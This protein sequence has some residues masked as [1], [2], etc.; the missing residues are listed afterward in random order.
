MRAA[1][2]GLEQWLLRLTHLRVLMA[3]VLL[4]FGLSQHRPDSWNRLV[5]QIETRLFSFV[6]EWM[7][8]PAS[9]AALTVIQVPDI[10]FDAWQSDPTGD[11]ELAVLLGSLA[12]ARLDTGD[13]M[14]PVGVWIADRPLSVIQTES[15]RRMQDWLSS[16]SLARSPVRDEAAELAARRDQ[17]LS[18]LGSHVIGLK[19]GVSPVA[20]EPKSVSLPLPVWASAF[21]AWRSAI[22]VRDYP[23]QATA[24][25]LEYLSVADAALQQSL[26]YRHHSANSVAGLRES[27]ALRAWRLG[28]L[29]H[30]HLA[31]SRDNPAHR[32]LSPVTW[33]QG[34]PLAVGGRVLNLGLDG[35]IL[36][37][38][39]E[40]TALQAPATQMTLAAALKQIAAASTPPDWLHGWVLW[41]REGDPSLKATAQLIAAIEDTAYLT[42]PAWAPWVSGVAWFLCAIILLWGLPRLSIGWMLVALVAWTLIWV[43]CQTLLAVWFHYWLGLAEIT[44][45]L[46][47]G[48]LWWGLVRVRLNAYRNLEQGLAYWAYEAAKALYH[49]ERYPESLAALR[50]VPLT[51]NTLK[52]HYRLAG[53]LLDNHYTAE[54]L[55]LWRRIY[56]KAK[57]FR[58]VEAQLQAAEQAA[59]IQQPLQKAPDNDIVCVPQALEQLGRYQIQGVLG[60]GDAGLVYLGFDPVIERHVA[61]KVLNLGALAP[62]VQERVA[63]QFNDQL[64]AITRLTHPNI[65]ALVDH[66][67]QLPWFFMAFERVDAKPLGY[68][69]AT[70]AER[71][72]IAEIYGIGL[73]V[74]QA[75][76]A[77]HAQGIVHGAIKP[78]NILYDRAS[79]L[80]KVTDFGLAH[81]LDVM[82]TEAGEAIGNPRYMAPEQLEGRGLVPQ[83]D[84]FSLGAVLYELLA[85]QPAF[86]AGVS[87]QSSSRIEAAVLYHEP[88]PIRQLNP[89]VPPGA[90]RIVQRALKKKTVER[91]AR[92]SDLVFTLQEA[93]Q[94]DYPEAAARWI[95]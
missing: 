38:Y 1:I 15:H 50:Q 86:G 11:P 18:S 40:L 82:Q 81:W 53:A 22:R 89:E 91:Y 55:S 93:L 73:R 51:V 94:R 41:G 37:L 12:K 62:V 58:D 9:H 26:I 32:F 76:V 61:L 59:L 90:A 17:A 6:V 10:A 75:L 19:G 29:S 56:K 24:S 72:S 48:C 54:A 77:A 36:P 84:C 21:L 3:L 60:H 57:D 45:I 47:G 67:E 2:I 14:P 65:V 35:Q 34:E 39:T 7:P 25:A 95:T 52:I 23:L 5:E 74:A 68:Y 43:L 79:G 83:T 31:P 85:G 78:S 70:A 33:Q 44:A 66:G 49:L 30:D 92:V 88:L 87:P 80:V 64:R 27:A 69:L 46:W 4:G 63:R 71:L 28:H 42:L 8:P 20:V 16:Q 13:K